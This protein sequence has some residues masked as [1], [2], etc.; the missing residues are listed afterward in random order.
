M[1]VVSVSNYLNFH[2]MFLSTYC[3]NDMLR[4]LINGG[5]GGRNVGAK[6]LITSSC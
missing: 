4:L 3:I 5:E 6:L 1:R 2:K